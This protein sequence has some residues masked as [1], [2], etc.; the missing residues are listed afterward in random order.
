MRIDINQKKISIGSQYIIYLNSKETYYAERELFT[1]FPIINLCLK[2]NY[3]DRLEI[4][5]RWS[6]IS[7]KYDIEMIDGQRLEFRTKSTWNLHYQCTTK[8]DIYDIYGHSGRKY[9][10][11]KNEKQI[12][13][14]L[15]EA[16]TFLAGDNYKI[17]ANND[18]EHELIIAFCLILDNASSKTNGSIFT[19]NIG[20][21]GQETKEFNTRWKPR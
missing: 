14:W 18:T 19:L 7:P 9:S 10:I 11:Y 6:W 12:A 21:I 4:I 1:I 15:E 16:V 8:N 5:K 17:F 3:I 13:Y 20:N 2:E